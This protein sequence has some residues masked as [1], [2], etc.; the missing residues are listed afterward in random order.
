MRYVDL[1]VWY[2]LASGAMWGL[3]W[4]LTRSWLEGQKRVASAQF[5]VFQLI[6]SAVF[7]AL[8]AFVFYGPYDGLKL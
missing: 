4:S 5:L 3:F 8:C 7:L 2:V 6:L 1:F